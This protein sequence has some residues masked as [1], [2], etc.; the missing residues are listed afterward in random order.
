[1]STVLFHYTHG[2]LSVTGW[3][4]ILLILLASLVSG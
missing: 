3:G 2:D 4:L 1:M